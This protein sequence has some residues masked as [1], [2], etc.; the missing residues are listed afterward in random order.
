M[1][2]SGLSF[3]NRDVIAV[4]GTVERYRFGRGVRGG[5]R[6]AGRGRRGGRRGAAGAAL[7]RRE[8]LLQADARALHALLLPPHVILCYRYGGYERLLRI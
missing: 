1:H 6:G 5:R 8:R 7:R 2:T 4:G 3:S